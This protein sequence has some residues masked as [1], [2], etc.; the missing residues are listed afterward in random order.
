MLKFLGRVFAVLVGLFVFTILIVLLLSALGAEKPLIIADNSVLKIKLDREIREK[1]QGFVLNG[2]GYE[3]NSVGLIEIKEALSRAASEDKIRGILLEVNSVKAGFASASEIREALVNFKKS[4]KFIYAYGESYSE[5]AYYLASTA[6]KIYLAPSGS[7]EFNGFSSEIMFFKKALE[8][9]EIK[10]EIFRV[11][12]YKSAVEPFFLEKMSDANREQTSSFMNSLY[13]S[14]LGNISVSR[15]IPV[16][17]LKAISDSLLVRRPADA[18]KYK[19]IT[20]IGYYDEVQNEIKKMLKEKDEVE[21]V[22]LADYASS[23][24]TEVTDEGEKNTIAVIIA[25][26]EINSG[27]SKDNQ[28]IGADDVCEQLRQVR[29]NDKIKAVV[30]RINSP[31]GSA[32]ASDLMWREVQLTKAVK[33]VIA[34]MSD[35]AASGGYYMAMGCHKIVANPTTVTGSIGVFGLLVNATQFMNNKLGVTTD[36]VNTGKFSDL[37]SFTRDLTTEERAVI[38]ED[39]NHTYL[40]FTTKAA[41]GRKKSLE[42]LQKIASGRVWTG[43]Q[44]KENGLV[45]ELGGLEK[46]VEIAAASAKIKSYQV[47]YYPEKKSLIEDLMEQIDNKETAQ[48]NLLKKELGELYPYFVT[49]QKIKGMQ[50]VQSRLPFE[51]EF[52]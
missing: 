21:Y 42:D 36:R 22:S 34:S 15:D 30:L 33:P 18:L 52:K 20:N 38:Q 7:L 47:K 3:S 12:Q 28:T 39:V 5:G 10:P 6:D 31:G 51:L 14:F 8:K 16:A 9:L 43:I 45:D 11:G 48:V 17:R 44:A 24:K 35:Y 19:L 50:G 13:A 37:G 49:L 4:G 46:A 25:S 29:E 2:F 27:K 32:L 41:E 23:L 26:G 40:D 1:G